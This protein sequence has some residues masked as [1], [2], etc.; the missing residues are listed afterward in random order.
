MNSYKTHIENVDNEIEIEIFFDYQP[1]ESM[2]RHSPPVPESVDI[3][4]VLIVDTNIEL[5]LLKDVEG[6][7]EE[8]IMEYRQ[9]E[10]NAYD[11]YG[12]LNERI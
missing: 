9:E 12:Y 2:T 8:E 1:Y 10:L 11:G 5:C 3:C 6:L 4:E 7:M